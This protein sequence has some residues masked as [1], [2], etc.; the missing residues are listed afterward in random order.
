MWSSPP[1]QATY[2]LHPLVL[3]NWEAKWSSLLSRSIRL[4]LALCTH[5]TL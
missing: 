4:L 1:T 5:H 3:L 2:V